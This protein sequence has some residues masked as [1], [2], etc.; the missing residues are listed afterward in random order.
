MVQ[1]NVSPH[2]TDIQRHGHLGVL[3]GLASFGKASIRSMD[4]DWLQAPKPQALG[5]PLRIPKA[6]VSHQKSVMSR[7]AAGAEPISHRTRTEIT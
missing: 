6:L 7:H 2:E 4:A 3:E 5:Q 1:P